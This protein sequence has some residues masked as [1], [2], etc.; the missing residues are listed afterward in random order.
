MCW[1]KKKKK[2]LS[3]SE[4]L[5]YTFTIHFD[6]TQLIKGVSSVLKIDES[7]PCFVLIEVDDVLPMNNTRCIKHIW[8][9]I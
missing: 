4:M 2:V 9:G 3:Y 5:I 7:A 1:L 6:F 8:Y